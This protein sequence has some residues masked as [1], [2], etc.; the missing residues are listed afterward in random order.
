VVPEGNFGRRN[1]CSSPKGML[2][3]LQLS[4]E[5]GS[6]RTTPFTF[7]LAERCTRINLEGSRLRLESFSNFRAL[8][9]KPDAADLLLI[10]GLYVTE[11]PGA[12]DGAARKGS[13][14]LRIVWGGRSLISNVIVTPIA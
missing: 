1:V 7:T 9:A 2:M 12:K 11:D 8:A 4:A 13:L 6:S 5:G 10:A 14:S 3:R